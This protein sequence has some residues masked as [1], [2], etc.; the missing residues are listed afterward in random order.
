M[1]T[2]SG[3]ANDIIGELVLEEGYVSHDVAVAPVGGN[4]NGGARERLTLPAGIRCCT[5]KANDYAYGKLHWVYDTDNASKPKR[6]ARVTPL[7][8]ALVR[9]DG[10]ASLVYSLSTA[11]NS[12]RTAN[13]NGWKTWEAQR[14]SDGAWIKIGQ[15]RRK[16]GGGGFHVTDASQRYW[17][18][19]RVG[20]SARA[21]TSHSHSYAPSR[22]QGR[23]AASVFYAHARAASGGAHHR[24]R[25]A[26]RDST[27]AE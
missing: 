4:S 25:Q 17:D 5:G 1:T 27:S 2:S 10:S 24:Y 7:A 6:G 22:R 19:W 13:S 8:G 15:F 14:P 12:V 21:Q 3:D 23:A 16:S 26:R 9:V 18:E 20:A 11:A